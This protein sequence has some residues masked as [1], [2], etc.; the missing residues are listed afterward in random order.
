MFIDANREDL[1]KYI[2]TPI[3]LRNSDSTF[4]I[5]TDIIGNNNFVDITKGKVY[6]FMTILYED[7]INFGFYFKKEDEDFFGVWIDD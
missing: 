1:T 5:V 4:Y 7:G 3:K 6:E 2:G